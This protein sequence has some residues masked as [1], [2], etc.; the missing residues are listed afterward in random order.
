MQP[1]FGYSVISRLVSFVSSDRPIS[2]I[3]HRWGFSDTSH[4]SRNFK[5]PYG[6]SPAD[7]RNAYCP[8]PGVLTH[9]Y[10][11]LSRGFK[12]LTH[13][14]RRLVSQRFKSGHE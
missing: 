5:A 6:C 9:R 10:S 4:F 11:D 3:S 12:P 13:R 1:Q 2:N 14:V 8:R 7:S